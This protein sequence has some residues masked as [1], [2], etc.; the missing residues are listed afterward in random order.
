MADLPGKSRPRRIKAHNGLK[1]GDYVVF[2]SRRQWFGWVVKFDK[3]HNSG[4]WYA[5]MRGVDGNT[6]NHRPIHLRK[7]PTP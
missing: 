4:I 2:G 5:T 7:V 3:Y 6:S 1:V